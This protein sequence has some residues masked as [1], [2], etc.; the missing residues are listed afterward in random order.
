MCDIHTMEYY[1]SALKRKEI[2]TYAATWLKLEDSMV[3]EI[4]QSQKDKYCMISLTG[5]TQNS[6]IQRQKV[7]W[8]FLGIR[9]RGEWELLLFSGYRVSVLQDEKSPGDGWW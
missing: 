4:S 8:W 7:T 3:N 2:L 1:Y 9:W 5:G 6:Q